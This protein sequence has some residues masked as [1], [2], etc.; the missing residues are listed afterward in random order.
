MVEEVKEQ[1]AYGYVDSDVVA[2]A[3]LASGVPA[4]H[5]FTIGDKGVS[6]LGYKGTNAINLTPAL[7]IMSA[8]SSSPMSRV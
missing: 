7:E 4:A 3:Y 1:Y 6:R 2:D 8:I 5:I